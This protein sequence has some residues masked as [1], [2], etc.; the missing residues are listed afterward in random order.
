MIAF[1][2]VKINLLILLIYPVGIIIARA[3]TNHFVANPQYYLF[4]FFLSHF[5]ALI[6]LLIYKVRKNIS[7]N[8]K[9]EQEKLDNLDSKSR[10]LSF[11]QTNPQDMKNQIEVLKEKIKRDKKRDKIL[12][13]FLIGILYFLTY[14]F[15]YYF[16]Y[17]TPTNFYGNI[18][19][20]TEVL[21][22]SLFNWTIFG[23]KIYSHHC[24]AMILIT[25]SIFSLYILL[26]IKYMQIYDCDILN[27]LFYP[28]LL[29]FFVYG[30]FCFFLIKGKA[31]IEK[32]FISA[33]E[34]I[35]Y[36]GLL[37]LSILIIFEPISFFISCHDDK[38]MYCYNNHFAGIISGFKQSSNTNGFFY[39][40]GLVVSLFMTSLG[41]WLTVKILSPLHFLTS[42]SII[43]FELN[44]LMDCHFENYILVKDP[45]F[46]ILSFI[47][48]FACL[49]YNEII[50]IKIYNLDY[51]TRKQ[52]IKRQSQDIKDIVCELPDYLER[53]TTI[54]S[55]TENNNIDR[56]STGNYVDEINN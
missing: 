32:Y 4:L 17:I 54:T 10:E 5:L 52:I 39:S 23:N 21:Y 27:D 2:E 31:Y 8:R 26:I 14:G 3:I 41:L 30:P 11:N 20:V 15:F 43:T 29:N 35:I 13:F 7:K 56:S 36:L 50:V 51:N 47:T 37:S 48:I 42:D 45:L 25:F 53:P 12:L 49:I 19:M 38:K 40:F 46:Y 34:L 55:G 44:I 22:F 28:S 33:Y 16:N 24:F 18:S 1:G 6:P 9:I